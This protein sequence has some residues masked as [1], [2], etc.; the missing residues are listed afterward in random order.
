MKA[1]EAVVSGTRQQPI[2][3]DESNR[4]LVEPE[5]WAELIVSLA[6][7]WKKHPGEAYLHLY[8]VC[9]EGT[10]TRAGEHI[11]MRALRGES[12]S[13]VAAQIRKGMDTLGPYPD[14]GD[15]APGALPKD[16]DYGMWL[17]FRRLEQYF[18]ADVMPA[19]PTVGTR[20]CPLPSPDPD[21]LV[22]S[23]KT[24]RLASR[25]ATYSLADVVKVFGLVD[26]DHRK[27]RRSSKYVARTENPK[28]YQLPRHPSK[29][30]PSGRFEALPW[31]SEEVLRAAEGWARRLGLELEGPF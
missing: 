17:Y 4:F 9:D 14:P 30:G 1:V 27:V 7:A 11:F 15:R 21:V 6:G 8:P 28:Y 25:E 29:H 24:L 23:I 18:D 2:V 13:I 22:A 12:V 31:S 19:P 3:C 20:A 16:F 26:V 10:G 5:Y